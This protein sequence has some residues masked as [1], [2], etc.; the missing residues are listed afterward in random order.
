MPSAEMR[1]G[2]DNL[3]DVVQHTCHLKPSSYTGGDLWLEAKGKAAADGPEVRRGRLSGAKE[4]VSAPDT[5][6]DKRPGP[7]Q[8][9][10]DLWLDAKGKS[11]VPGPEQRRGRPNLTETFQQLSNPYQDGRTLGDSWLE[12]KGR[13]VTPP[14]DSDLRTVMTDIVPPPAPRPPVDVRKYGTHLVVDM[15]QI[16]SRV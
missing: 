2:R 1:R 7:G 13:K 14:K 9:Y 12:Y 5:L 15:H 11:I 4:L 8:T 6:Q 10:G 16:T 3:Y